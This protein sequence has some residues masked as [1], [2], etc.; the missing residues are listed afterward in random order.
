MSMD[1]AKASS[2]DQGLPSPPT[3]SRPFRSRKN[4][5]C[6][7]C[8]RAKT[9]C[10]IPAAGPPCVECQQTRKQCTFDQLPPERKKPSKRPGSPVSGSVSP[11]GPSSS[12]DKRP[13]V[14][15]SASMSAQDN[16]NG[17]DA[18][19]HAASREKRLAI[20]PYPEPMSLDLSTPDSLD[21]HVI[22]ALLTDD[23]LPI[24]SKQAGPDHTQLPD[25][26]YIRQ[27]STVSS[28]PQYI[29]FT[30]KPKKT[31]DTT[32]LE[33]E[34]LLRLDASLQ[35]LRPPPNER[36][37]QE[38]FFT[39]FNSAFPLLLP[40]YI[41]PT[42]HPS[43]L[44]KLY[45]A[46]LVHTRQYRHSAKAVRRLVHN[47]ASSCIENNAPL[48]PRLHSIAGAILE[49]S[50]RPVWDAESRYIALSRTIAQAQLMGLHIDPA[51]WAIPAWEK[52]HRRVLWWSLRI[53]DGWM[54]FLNSRPSHIQ[55]DNAN[56][57]L[58]ALTSML[59][60]SAPSS[61]A[62]APS[63]NGGPSIKAE[64]SEAVSPASIRSLQSF[65]Y[66]CRIGA[67]VNR[68]QAQVCTLTAATL[69][70]REERLRRVQDL[71]ADA[72]ALLDEVKLEWE[73]LG[74]GVSGR[75]K[76]SGIACLMTT[77]LCFRCMLR[78][79]SIELYIG[80][81]SPFVPD[82]DTL[83]IFA[84]TV[85][86]F[87]LLDGY[88][89]DSFWI[90]Y[91]GHILSSVTSSLIR[92]SLAMAFNHQQHLQQHLQQQQQQQPHLQRPPP[93]PSSFLAPA[94]ARTCPIVL[95]SRLRNAL[96]FARQEHDWDC[97]DAGLQR[98]A[99][100]AACLQSAE[101]YAGIVN[102][103]QGRIALGANCGLHIHQG[104][105]GGGEMLLGGAAGVMPPG[106]PM[107]G[108]DQS[109]W[110]IDLSALGLDW[111]YDGGFDTWG[112]GRGPQMGM[113]RDAQMG[114]SGTGAG[115]G[116]SGMGVGMPAGVPSPTYSQ[117]S[118]RRVPPDGIH[119]EDGV[120]N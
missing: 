114:V 24:G 106:A 1:D 85:D 6:D 50:S 27:I 31:Q 16:P 2:S 43:L 74:I 26:S 86:Y 49:L 110:N 89:F 102:A 104:P 48:V 20:S 111:G 69:T 113:G 101:E 66:Q 63:P 57:P 120:S 5:P 72:N 51:N 78:R 112:G 14:V 10:A 38:L 109:A 30:Q 8:R 97:A 61:P 13:R 41:N 18:L 45:L 40:Q 91:I 39:H 90:S 37:L 67:L 100:V 42:D 46:A 35:L 19:I 17:L 108:I 93:P 115:M 58:P 77:L 81:G 64:P 23:L 118:L 75:M 116:M 56:V 3:L 22:T 105:G 12:S 4:R 92:L 52:E 53:H 62:S 79:I 32:Q 99:N 44:L 103:L 33:R 98:T 107:Q 47:G 59:A 36:L 119:L 117:A 21:P 76:P 68:L 70:S 73:E 80:L 54:S 60:T 65:L 55:L 87:C 82:D 29:I 94:P 95:L 11:G 88:D 9:R 71:E 7:A 28:K 83:T 34:A 96:H 15:S 25:T 84:D